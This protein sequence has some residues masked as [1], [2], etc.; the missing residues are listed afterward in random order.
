[1]TV[2]K[3]AVIIGGGLSGLAAAVAL[4][5]EGFKVTVLERKPFLGGRASSYPVPGTEDPQGN[6]PY[7]DNCQHVLLKSNTNLI[8]FYE[9]IGSADGIVYSKQIIFLDEKARRATLRTSPLPAPLHLLPSFLSFQP[10]KAKDKLAIVYGL[11]CMLRTGNSKAEL[12]RMT[13]MDWLRNHHQTDRAVEV[14]W[15]T[16]LVSALNEDIEIASARYGIKVF[17]DGLLRHREAFH[18]GIPAI[19]LSKLYTDRSRRTFIGL[20][21]RQSPMRSNIPQPE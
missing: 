9:R 19:P 5:E 18:V 7:I 10:L 8:N 15:R 4:A 1:M 6:Q 17:L 13:M 11:F 20:R 14:F 2:R 21:R 12:D 16:I 3:H